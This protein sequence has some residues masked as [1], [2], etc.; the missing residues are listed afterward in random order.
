[1]R[2]W[3]EESAAKKQA[4][5]E[6][7]ARLDDMRHRRP[8]TPPQSRDA[9]RRNSSEVRRVDEQRRAEE[10][11]RRPDEP[12]HANDAYHPSEAAHHT[13]NHSVGSGHL[14]P[15]QQT[16][17]TIGH[18]KPQAVATPKEERPPALEQNPQARPAPLVA[19]P[20]RAARKMDVDEDYDDSG[21]DEKKAAV[22]TNGSGP[23]SSSGEIKTSTPTTSN[24]N[25][26]SGPVPKVE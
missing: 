4:N 11:S 12:R 24:V 16:P 5:E 3:E 21:E 10:A 23:G 13:Q 7:R 17:T 8:S 26:A 2:D 1:M 22:L 25:G 15:M 6:N 18:E 14:P 20:E 19:E 9:Y